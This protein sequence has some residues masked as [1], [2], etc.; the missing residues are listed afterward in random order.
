VILKWLSPIPV[1]VEDARDLAPTV[2]IVVA[3]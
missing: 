1:N 3:E 2:R